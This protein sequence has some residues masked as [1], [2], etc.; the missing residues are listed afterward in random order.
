MTFVFSIKL[1][2]IDKRQIRDPSV[3]ENNV[4]IRFLLKSNPNPN[5]NISLYLYV[6]CFLFYVVTLETDIM[7]TSAHAK[8]FG[9]FRLLLAANRSCHNFV[10]VLEAVSSSAQLPNV[11]ASSVTA[12]IRAGCLWP[13]L[14]EKPIFKATTEGRSD[15]VQLKIK[16]KNKSLS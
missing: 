3:E 6:L 9:C 10:I 1:H 12:D 14:H 5:P 2:S 11:L 8:M 7:V 15:Y 13:K 4:E 16:T